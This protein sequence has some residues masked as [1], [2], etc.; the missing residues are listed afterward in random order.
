[1]TSAFDKR[2]V[3]LAGSGSGSGHGDHQA[4]GNLNSI[5]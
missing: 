3:P 1:M 2:G 4:A 5:I